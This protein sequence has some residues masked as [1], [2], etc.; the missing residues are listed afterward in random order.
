MNL[1]SKE[2]SPGFNYA[3][4][5]RADAP[6]VGFILFQ[7]ASM[8]CPASLTAQAAKIAIWCQESEYFQPEDL[9]FALLTDLPKLEKLV[10][11][12]NFVHNQRGVKTGVI[13]EEVSVIVCSDFLTAHRMMGISCHD[14][15]EVTGPLFQKYMRNNPHGLSNEQRE[16][17]FKKIIN[18]DL[19][20]K[21]PSFDPG[22]TVAEFNMFLIQAYK[23]R[24]TS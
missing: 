21:Y 19:I 17:T 4:L 1:T 13:I 5:K 14:L 22:I 20:V 12:G 23:A 15:S 7:R 16:A 2:S 8:E 6:T 24:P 9:G 3:T 11:I 10:E 18:L